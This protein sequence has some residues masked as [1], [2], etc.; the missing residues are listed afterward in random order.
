[1]FASEIVQASDMDRLVVL[2]V[3]LLVEN[4]LSATDDELIANAFDGI[5]FNPEK[6]GCRCLPFYQC[7]NGTQTRD[8]AGLINY[9]LITAKC[10]CECQDITQ[11][12]CYSPPEKPQVETT[13]KP[14]NSQTTSTPVT[15]T[16]EP[17]VTTSKPK[18]TP[19]RPR[20][21][22]KCGVRRSDILDTRIM[23]AKNK[24]KSS[25]FPWMVAIF[26]NEVKD[27]GDQVKRYMCAGSLIHERVVMTVAHCANQLKLDNIVVRAGAWNL[28]SNDEPYPHQDRVV[29]QIISHS[30]FNARYVT[31]D[32]AL[33]VT[34]TPFKFAINVDIICL[35]KVGDVINENSCI[36]AG[37]GKN[38]TG[39]E[40][41]TPQSIPQTTP[42]RFI[43]PY[44]LDLNFGGGATYH[45]EHLAGGIRDVFTLK[46]NPIETPFGT[47]NEFVV[48]SE[49]DY[50]TPKPHSQRPRQ[51][52]NP[53]GQYNASAFQL[54]MKYIELP[55]VP[56]DE[57]ESR[58]QDTRL[59]P[60]FNL[61]ESVMCAGGIEGKDAC[62]GD[63][64]SPLICPIKGVPFRYQQ[65]GIVA[66]GIGCGTAVPALYADVA[67]LRP[68]INQ[69]V[70]QLGF[71]PAYD[72]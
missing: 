60:Y 62:Q 10:S 26:H 16:S 41:E 69:Q 42:K 29:S 36:A 58:L 53:T 33:L 24:T 27:G 3:L 14:V 68:W 56:K 47:L 44:V 12:C 50:P 43:R 22:P 8:G 9:R 67:Y 23:G 59:G 46:I 31:N 32:V 51:Q 61:H 38:E 17:E 21:K 2:T 20:R 11:R 13:K 48:A 66:A 19:T 4:V 37:W 52:P 40:T 45:L 30:E 63:G 1:M 64:G 34:T 6:G 39:E 71:E 25:E 18:R 70:T 57:C 35:P 5:G 49:R 28:N 54:G 55:T 15:T 65:V 72:Y 7:Q